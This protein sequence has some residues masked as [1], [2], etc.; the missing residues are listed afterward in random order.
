[1]FVAAF[2]AALLAGVAL[3]SGP[4]P[5][6]AHERRTI[7]ENYQ[8]VVGWN[9]EPAIG[10]QPNAVSLRV[11]FFEGGVPGE[12]EEDAEG[13]PVEGVEETLDV[14]VSTGGGAASID[15]PMEAAFGEVG[16]YEST[17]IIPAP[18]DYSFAFTGTLPDGTEVNE[19]FESG[20][21][22]FATV[23][24]P[25]ELMF[26]QPEDGGSDGSSSESSSDD[27]DDNTSTIA[28]IIGLIAIVVAAGAV[29]L[30]LVGFAR[31]A[32]S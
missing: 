18:G 1:L 26:P 24:D 6:S 23:D 10:G 25:A 20:P 7:A 12:E 21:D 30:G 19:T 15:L 27:D 3:L 11:T 14:T 29:I 13:T 2:A 17:P 31:K 32:S 8:F 4:G 28:L 9:A 16:V 22:T 5:V